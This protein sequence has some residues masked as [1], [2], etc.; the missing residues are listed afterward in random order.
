MPWELMVSAAAGWNRQS[1][2]VGRRGGLGFVVP[3]EWHGGL[4][5]MYKSR[6]GGELQIWIC[7]CFSR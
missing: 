5:S 4:H 1:S 3:I 7:C 6:E 2:P